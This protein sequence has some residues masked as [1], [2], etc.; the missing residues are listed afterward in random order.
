M[1]GNMRADK[2]VRLSI[3]QDKFVWAAQAATSAIAFEAELQKLQRVNTKAASYLRAI[4][5]G[6]WALYPHMTQRPLFGWRT[7]N[8]VESEQAKSLNLK[9][10]M[11]LPFEFFKTYA[12]IL[13]GDVFKRSQQVQ[14]WEKAGRL[15][16]PR[17]E[18]KFQTQLKEAEEYTSV[19]SDEHVAYVS[20]VTQPLKQRLVDTTN[21]SC[22]CETWLQLKIPCRHLI[23]A[24]NGRGVLPEISV[25]AGACYQVATYKTTLGA[26]RIPEDPQLVSDPSVLPAKYI[27][28][29]GRPKKRRIRSRGEGG[30]RVRRPYKC[31]KCGST[32]GHNR[33]TCRF[34]EA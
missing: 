3:S 31:G 28:Q 21:K 24:L 25:L 13:M 32:D 26:L 16:T 11:M 27:R 1:L 33:A 7:T 15:I 2:S 8:F 4:P 17:A 9:P 12:T 34:S 30:D 14:R 18:A 6:S 22:S 29:A 5:V 23:A 20:R 10:R 19:G